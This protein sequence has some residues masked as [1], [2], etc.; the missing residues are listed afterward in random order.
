ML[1]LA[2]FWA[3]VYM[4]ENPGV[5]VYVEG[6]G[7]ATGMAAL[8]RGDIDICMASR[9]IWPE[10]AQRLVE[11]FGTV[12]VSI[13]VA[14]DALSIYV[15]PD[16]PV[17]NLTIREI[18]QI[19]SGNIDNWSQVD[20]DDASIQLLNR[21]PTSGTFAYF[22][23]HVLEGLP[24]SATGE[25]LATTKAVIET[26]AEHEY[27]I[28]YGG[29]AYEA[30]VYHIDINGVAPTRENVMNDTY[31]ITRYLYLYTVDTPRGKT[32]NFINWVLSEHGQD[33]VK[34]VGYFPIWQSEP[35]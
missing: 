21:R 27:A 11:N 30:D 5:S 35:D 1:P 26:V 15:H 18:R 31:P 34:W 7:T 16:N 23:E 9:T 13:L 12:G 32:K 2:R 3:E 10:E 4:I 17:K 28:G 33:I 25:A 22:Q 24:Y 29:I 19:Y 8:A 6:G 20:G 14:K